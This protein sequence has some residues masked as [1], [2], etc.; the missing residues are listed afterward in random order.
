MLPDVRR[1]CRRIL[2]KVRSNTGFARL[3]RVEVKTDSLARLKAE[4]LDR[5]MCNPEIDREWTRIGPHIEES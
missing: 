5:L 3:P 4:T 2:Q 1:L